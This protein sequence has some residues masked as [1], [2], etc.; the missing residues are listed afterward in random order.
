M[1]RVL[2]ACVRIGPPRMSCGGDDLDG[3]ALDGLNCVV[4]LARQ[5]S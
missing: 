1:T 5:C 3:S 2:N 4:L